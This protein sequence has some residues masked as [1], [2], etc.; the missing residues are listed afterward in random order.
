G[1]RGATGAT[2]AKGAALF[3]SVTYNADFVYFTLMAKD[4]L[5]NYIVLTVPRVPGIT[6]EFADGALPVAMNFGDVL[7][8]NFTGLTSGNYNSLVAEFIPEGGAWGMETAIVP[9]ANPCLEIAEPVFN[10]GVCNSTTITIKQMIET[11]GF[12]ALLRV[13]LT[14][15]KAT[16]MWLH[17]L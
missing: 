17:V 1:D 15:K 8:I 10:N 11:G 13:T 12:E 14:D 4:N 16:N 2:G 7:T 3:K 9:N 6:I 5:G